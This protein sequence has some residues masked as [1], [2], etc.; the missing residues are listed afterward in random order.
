MYLKWVGIALLIVSLILG[1]LIAT[2]TQIAQKA[3][4]YARTASDNSFI[5]DSVVPVPPYNRTEGL[6]T[7][8]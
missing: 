4:S 8:G 6:D 5:M 3:T 7:W 2:N 1:L